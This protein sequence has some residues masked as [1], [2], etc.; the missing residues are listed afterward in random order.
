MGVGRRRPPTRHQ[1]V[2]GVARPLKKL[3]I[4]CGWLVID[5]LVMDAQGRKQQQNATSINNATTKNTT[6]YKI[7]NKVN[8]SSTSKS[9]LAMLA[10]VTELMAGL[11]CEWKDTVAHC[12]VVRVYLLAALVLCC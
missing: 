5:A 6:I 10:E 11:T 4:Q 12:C 9:M 8:A 2:S 7:Y 1:V 3:L